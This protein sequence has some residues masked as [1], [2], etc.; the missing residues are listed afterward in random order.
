MLIRRAFYRWQFPAAVVLPVWLL[1]GWGLFVR[2]PMSF[3]GVLIG[4]IVLAIALAA[5]SGLIRARKS[6]RDAH[7]LAWPDVAALAAWQL[8]I[9]GLGFFGATSTLFLV[10]TVVFA[11]CAFWLS[12]W[13]LLDETR[14]RVRDAV[15]SVQSVARPPTSGRPG[16]EDG[17]VI[18]VH[19]T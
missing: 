6:V 17:D 13:S 4:G 11:I 14:R 16:D 5:V 18:I 7:A 1:V 9:V 3:V 19:E 8:S 12:I 15:Q 10:L 2:T